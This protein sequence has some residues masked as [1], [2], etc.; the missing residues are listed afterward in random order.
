MQNGKGETYPYVELTDVETN[1]K[2]VY[3]SRSEVYKGSG[4]KF[5]NGDTYLLGLPQV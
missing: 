3:S 1:Y 5:E 2:Y 4:S